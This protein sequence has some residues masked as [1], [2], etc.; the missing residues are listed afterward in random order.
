[1]KIG[2]GGCWTTTNGCGEGL[3]NTGVTGLRGLIIGGEGLAGRL[4]TDGVNGVNPPPIICG[5]G[6]AGRLIRDGV[7]IRGLNSIDGDIRRPPSRTGVPITIGWG[8]GCGTG[9]WKDC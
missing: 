6:L 7:I 9:A 2:A 1:M 5:A 3:R 4:I 8:C